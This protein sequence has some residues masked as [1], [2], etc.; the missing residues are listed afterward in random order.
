MYTGTIVE[1]S[2]NDNRLLNS[3]EIKSVKISSADNKQDRWHLYKVY[4]SKEQISKLSHELKS[5]KWYMHFW[6]GDDVIAV[7]PNKA[8][9]FSYSDKNTWSEAVKH[10]LD[11]GIPAE[12]L[13]FVI[14]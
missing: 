4:V 12:Q 6:N 2:L 3:L 7:F 11:L 8:F 9:S 1:E 5:E 13:D 14:E 10:G